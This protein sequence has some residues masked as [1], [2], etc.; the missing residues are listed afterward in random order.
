VGQNNFS[1]PLI[2]VWVCKKITFQ[3]LIIMSEPGAPGLRVWVALYLTVF[4]MGEVNLRKTGQAGLR[5]LTTSIDKV[6]GSGGA[7]GT[8]P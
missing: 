5:P 8:R 1:Y 7:E 2:R 3:S 4:S 6:C